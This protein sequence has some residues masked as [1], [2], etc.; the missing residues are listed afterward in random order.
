MNVA[1][2]FFFFFTHIY[3]MISYNPSDSSLVLIPSASHKYLCAK[4]GSL[5]KEVYASI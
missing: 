2:P 5:F 1:L 3:F 4:S